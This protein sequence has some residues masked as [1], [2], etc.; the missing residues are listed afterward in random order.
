EVHGLVKELHSIAEQAI[1]LEKNPEQSFQS[2]QA[3]ALE[4]QAAEAKDR[5]ARFETV[6]TEAWEQALHTF[7]EEGA[8]KEFILHPTDQ[9]YN[10]KVVKPIQ[11]RA[12]ANFG[13]LMKE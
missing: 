7:K 13:G 1:E 3:Q 2:L 9:E 11:H 10:E 8:Y 12:A 4:R 6:A 5:R